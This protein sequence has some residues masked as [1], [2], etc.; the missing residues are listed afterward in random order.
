M[1]IKSQNENSLPNSRPQITVI[2]ANNNQKII[3]NTINNIDNN[4]NILNFNCVN[5]NAVVNNSTANIE[6]NESY[7]ND[8]IVDTD[9]IKL[10]VII[11]FKL[12][13]VSIILIILYS[14]MIRCKCRKIIIKIVNKIRSLSK[15]L[16]NKFV[17][18]FLNFK[19]LIRN[20]NNNDAN[21]RKPCNCTKS[22]CLKL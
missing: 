9:A 15:I 12:N 20:A 11:I 16:K 22:M 3:H 8:N 1:N 7:E 19:N 2:S 14:S 13:A 4:S 18:L 6:L 5:N 21:N 10:I 17:V